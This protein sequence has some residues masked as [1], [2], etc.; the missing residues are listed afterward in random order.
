MQKVKPYSIFKFLNFF[1]LK[2]VLTSVFT[3]DK[4]SSL[5]FNQGIIHGDT[6]RDQIGMPK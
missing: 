5:V 6:L 1:F 3:K 4:T 2:L